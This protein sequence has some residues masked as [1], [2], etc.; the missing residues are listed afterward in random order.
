MRRAQM[1]EAAR[2][3]IWTAAVGVAAL[4]AALGMGASFADGADYH[5]Q[6]PQGEEAPAAPPPADAD[7][8]P[9]TGGLSLQT[10]SSES[11]LE[12]RLATARRQ[13]E[14]AAR[15]VAELSAQLGTQE[16]RFF[17][18]RS[19][20]RGVVG[21]QLD[22]ASGSS[23]ASVVEVSPGGPASDA[24]IQRGDVIVA[25]NG[26]P[27]S[28]H[29]TARQV[30]EQM[31]RVA[32]NASV[33]LRVM[34]AGRPQQFELTT[35]PA[36]AFA[37][38]SPVGG[39]AYG[40]GPLESAASPAP[41]APPM[42]PGS[43]PV[44]VT[45]PFSGPQYFQALSEETAGMELTTLTPALGRYFGTDRGVLVLRAPTRDAFRLQDGDVILSIDGREPRNG[46]HATRILS[47]Y[48]PGERI[49]LKIMRQRKPLSLTLTLPGAQPEAA[50]R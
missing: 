34:R 15:Q 9:S 35:R 20:R 13:L 38:A 33:K 41:P 6:G 19:F 26:A 44:L 5:T 31:E 23:G 18:E 14:Q 17:V 12:A 7:S 28:G 4:G 39:E 42:P 1:A 46:A 21:L 36:F 29:D 16:N 48:Q 3:T 32:P 47:S 8:L 11:D 22:P 37:F 45:A 30:V 49:T 24:G 2:V 25:V 43:G 10:A 27:I 40:E 50:P